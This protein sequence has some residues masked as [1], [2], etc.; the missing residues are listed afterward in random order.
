MH[1]GTVAKPESRPRR[2][3]SLTAAGFYQQLG[4]GSAAW[5][6]QLASW[7]RPFNHFG[8]FTANVVWVPSTFIHYWWENKCLS[9]IL[10]AAITRLNHPLVMGCL[11]LHGWSSVWMLLWASTHFFFFFFLCMCFP[12]SKKKRKKSEAFFF[13]FPA[14]AITALLGSSRLLPWQLPVNIPAEFFLSAEERAP[15]FSA[16]DKSI[17]HSWRKCKGRREGG[18][19]GA[20]IP[21][22]VGGDG[23]KWPDWPWRVPAERPRLRAR[24]DYC[25]SKCRSVFVVTL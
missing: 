22:H 6:L 12:Y 18:E 3:V 8:H 17:G 11:L 25:R 14:Q 19:E 15:L 5:H 9:G 24:E 16:T 7:G 20:A 23:S 1:N 21:A 13:F 10:D 4:R 2:A